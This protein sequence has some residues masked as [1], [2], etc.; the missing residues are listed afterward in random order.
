MIALTDEPDRRRRWVL[1][2]VVIAL[3]LLLLLLIWDR[4]RPA[5]FAI[6]RLDAPTEVFANKARLPMR[7][8]RSGDPTFPLIL[9]DEPVDCPA[10]FTCRQVAEP[11]TDRSKRFAV[12]DLWFC[13]GTVRT[14]VTLAYR[15]WLTDAKGE[16]TAKVEAMSE[17]HP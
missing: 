15:F 6:T 14:P 10:T 4:S 16:T 11:V 9:H 13:T 12:P 1:L 8:T 5:H 3:L 17:C 7:V 2:A